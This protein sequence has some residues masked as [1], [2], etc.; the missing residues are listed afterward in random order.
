LDAFKDVRYLTIDGKK[1]FVIYRPHELPDPKAFVKCWR[2][3]AHKASLR[4]LYFIAV[5][6]DPK[7]VREYGFDA[8]V[9]E[10]PAAMVSR[11]A[12]THFW[13]RA[14]RF[15]SRRYNIWK[16]KRYYYGDVVKCIS[17]RGTA[18]VPC[19]PCIV[20]G[21]DVTPRYGKNGWL[22]H[23]STPELFR[24]HLKNALDQVAEDAPEKKVIF[25]KSWNEWS[26]GNYLEPDQRF[27]RAYLNVVKEEIFCESRS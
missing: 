13:L 15:F 2:D 7:M 8:I 3:L 1:V 21:W 6:C 5:S 26:E 10:E 22:L 20:P 18:D 9:P 4:G 27:G 25:I 11:F 23:G 17:R 16:G 19:F 24:S 12:A 14:R